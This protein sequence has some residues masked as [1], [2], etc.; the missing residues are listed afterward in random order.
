M[1]FIDKTSGIHSKIA[2][3]FVKY[4]IGKTKFPFS[5]KKIRRE[6]EKTLSMDEELTER[7]GAFSSTNTSRKCVVCYYTCIYVCVGVNVVML[8]IKI[9]MCFF[10][11]ANS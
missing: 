3:I 5:A 7:G 1:S 10:L 9:V 11:C 6:V 4:A 8:V 2:C